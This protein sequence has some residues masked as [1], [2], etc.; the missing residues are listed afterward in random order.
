MRETWHL[1]S[2]I[3]SSAAV[4]TALIKKAEN[5]YGII[6]PKIRPEKV[7]DSKMLTM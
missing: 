3:I 1:I 4:P 6:A 7:Y 2:R 5:R